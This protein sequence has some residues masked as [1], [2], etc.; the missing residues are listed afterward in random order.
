MSTSWNLHPFKADFISGKS[1]KSLRA[2]SGEQSGHSISVIDTGARNCLLDIGCLVSSS[3]DMEENPIIGPKFRPFPTCLSTFSCTA[4]ALIL[5]HLNIPEFAL[6]HQFCE[7]LDD[8][9]FHHL[10]HFCDGLW[11]IYATQKHLTFHSFSTLS[12]REHFTSVTCILS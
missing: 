10:W 2:K 5:K 8:H 6:F 9:V 1:Q 7:I 4:T 12:L 3:N 11:T